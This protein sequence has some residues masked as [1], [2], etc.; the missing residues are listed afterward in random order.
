MY[1]IISGERVLL[2]RDITEKER[3][4]TVKEKKK[5]FHAHAMQCN[6]L[7]IARDKKK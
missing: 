3:D 6:K 7:V 4:R 2:K 5:T 1:P